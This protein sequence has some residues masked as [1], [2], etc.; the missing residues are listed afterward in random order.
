MGKPEKLEALENLRKGAWRE[1]DSLRKHE[2]KVAISIWT[3]LVALLGSILLHPDKIF[4]GWCILAG[5]ILIILHGCY[6]LGVAMNQKLSRLQEIFFRDKTMSLLCIIE[7]YRNHDEIKAVIEKFEAKKKKRDKFGWF[8][9]FLHWSTGFQFWL[10]VSLVFVVI[11]AVM[12]LPKNQNVTVPEEAMNLVIY[13]IIYLINAAFA[14]AIIILGGSL[15]KT[16]VSNEETRWLWSTILGVLL[17][18]LG[19][20]V[21][22]YC[23]FTGHL[24]FL[25]KRDA[26]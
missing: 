17:I 24:A 20:A 23:L 7:E 8:G 4:W 25:L 5:I 10:T 22:I 15:I 12:F 26:A 6:I 21:F 2:W 13:L 18:L 3:S 14:L 9:P 19:A 11:F 1:I 16:G